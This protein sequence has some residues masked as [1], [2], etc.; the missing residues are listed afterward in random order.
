[1][2]FKNFS[3]QFE[4]SEGIIK[5][6]SIILFVF[7]LFML[8]GCATPQL[9]TISI[10]SP[11]DSAVQLLPDRSVGVLND[12][13]TI[14]DDRNS[15]SSTSKF[16][17]LNRTGH[18]LNVELTGNNG[19]YTFVIEPKRDQTWLVNQG[20]Y[21]VEISVPGFPSTATDNLNINSY[22]KYKWELWKTKH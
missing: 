20:R 5:Y 21:H 6:L 19:S 12:R 10:L 3:N 1:M 22:K 13:L 4:R 17:I 8:N 11:G 15:A 18:S 2:F 9:T 14:I 7:S 16:T